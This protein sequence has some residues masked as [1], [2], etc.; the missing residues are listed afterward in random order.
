MNKW[1]KGSLLRLKAIR[2]RPKHMHSWVP[3]VS[4]DA[5]RCASCRKT[6]SGMQMAT[7]RGA[8]LIDLFMPMDT[9]ELHR[10]VDGLTRWHR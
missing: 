7:K 6:V 9:D 4:R 5:W 3:S 2:A 8:E 10:L 1:I